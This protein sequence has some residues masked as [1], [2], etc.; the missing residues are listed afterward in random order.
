MVQAILYV[1]RFSKSC[2]IISLLQP[3]PETVSLFDEV[4]VL[5]EGKIM[6]AGTVKKSLVALIAFHVAAL[7]RH[8]VSFTGPVKMVEEY[9]ADIG[10]ICPRFTDTADFLQMVSTDDGSSLYKGTGTVPTV[11]ELAKA[12]QE[13]ELGQRIHEK[14]EL[15][16]NYLWKKDDNVSQ[17]NTSQVMS[18]AISEKVSRKYSNNFFYSAWLLL[19]RFVLLWTRDRRVIIA[20]AVKNVIMGLSVGGCYM[21]T[22]NVISIQG[23]LFQAGLFII[24]GAM[25]SASSLITDRVIYYKHTDANFYSAWPF[26][27]GRAMS[28]LPQTTID[29]I[30]FAT[31]LYFMVGLAGRE[32]ASNFFVYLSLLWVFA[33]LMSQQLAFFASFASAGSLQAFSACLVLLLILFCGFIIVPSTIPGYFVWLYWWNPFAWIYRALGKCVG[34]C[35]KTACFSAILLTLEFFHVVVNEFYSARWPDPEAILSNSGFIAPNGSP[36]GQEWVAY[37]YAFAIPYSILCTVSTA[38]S[39]TYIRSEG[40]TGVGGSE[41]ADD[42]SMLSEDEREAKTIEI[43]FT[44]V[45]LSFQDVCYDVTASTSKETLRLL[46]N[47]NGIFRAG[48]MCALMG[49]SGAGVSHGFSC[50]C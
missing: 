27:F 20:A 4:I 13:S 9:F 39:L 46:N 17:H 50:L 6:Y 47:V 40:G 14:L 48:R 7:T 35:Y 16:H 23:A 29:T 37:A 24:L 36:Y 12:F 10:Y 28:Q 44:P 22:E 30:M 1:A 11:A 32:S 42:S 25:Q 31:I 34:E 19:K 3:S 15:P 45:T 2:R 5:A 21:N 41:K 38:L 8:L 18:S 33:I 49:T 26:T 43:P